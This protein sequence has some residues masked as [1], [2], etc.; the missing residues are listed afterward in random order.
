MGLSME[1][2]ILMVGCSLCIKLVVIFD[3][4][5][6]SHPY[7][8]TTVFVCGPKAMVNDCWDVSSTRSLKG[9]KF[10]FHHET[11]EF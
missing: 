5:V 2:P 9:H 11:F 3:G 4:V 6:S 10:H 8:A 1:D 7:K